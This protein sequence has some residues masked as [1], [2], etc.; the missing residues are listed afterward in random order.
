MRLFQLWRYSGTVY[1]EV[2]YRSIQMSRGQTF[3][4]GSS[5]ESEV[6]RRHNSA[7][8]SAK[9][10]KI[11]FAVLG[12]IGSAF[13]FAE[14][15]VA[16][17]PEAL[18]SGVSLSLAISLAYIVFYTLQILPS[19]SSGEPYSIL[20]TLP[21][22]DRDFSLVAL[23]SLVRTFDYIAAS[24]IVVQ[25]LGILILTHSVVAS[26]LMLIG[27]VVNTVFAMALALWFSSVFYKNASRGGRST[28]S[29]IGRSVFLVA[30]GVGALSIGFIFN[31][32]S[33]LL[34]YVTGAILGMFTSPGGLLLLVIHPF[35][36]GFSIA[37]VVYPSLFASIPVPSSSVMLIP[38]FI[39]PIVAVGA[40]LAYAL[41]ALFLARRTMN[42]ISRITRGFG[43]KLSRPIVRDYVLTVRTPLRAYIVKDLRLASVNPS[44]AFLYA[45]PLFEVITLFV[46]TS[47]F[48][49]MRAMSMIV[50]TIVGCFFTAMICS[51]LLNTEG[52]GLEYTMSLPLISRTIVDAKAMIALMTF[53]PVPL[54]LLTIGLSKQLSSEYILLIPFVELLAV[55]A[56][57][58]GEITF[59][60][61]PD[62]NS[63]AQ[64]QSHGFSVMAGSDIGRLIESLII[65]FTIL[66]I[67]LVGY[68][69]AFILTANHANAID[70]MLAIALAELLVVVGAVRKGILSKGVNSILPAT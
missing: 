65:A 58:M 29:T 4:S 53:I 70:S 5:S 12:I 64:R 54:S 21:L 24:T 6:K 34:P 9:I 32:I 45:A 57:T 47:Q 44:L 14:Y 39:P 59:F 27:G 2:A 43:G 56:A 48:P 50:S 3:S 25:M 61:K 51:T 30:W 20:L 46:I 16:P 37:N 23:F 10:S 33:Y 41:L 67:P 11:A 42:S 69:A 63:S 18:I 66:L 40:S 17:T 55:C 68:S 31:F 13:P 15:A 26:I 19:F 1:R 28:S 35:S 62:S 60:L 52:A 49:V 36:M 7:M 8:G 22:E 38:R